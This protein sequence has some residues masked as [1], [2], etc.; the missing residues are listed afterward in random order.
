MDEQ[1]AKTK[2]N[3]KINVKIAARTGYGLRRSLMRQPEKSCWCCSAPAAANTNGL[4]LSI[5]ERRAGRFLTSM[6]SPR[7][8][9]PFLQPILSESTGSR[10]LHRPAQSQ[11]SSREAAKTLDG[12]VKDDMML[13][14]E[15]EWPAIVA[16]R[17][18]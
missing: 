5:A 9:R 3:V 6:L 15:I 17:M 18:S 4:E 16:G 10:S 2:L 12:T 7:S 8:L 14:N 11:E 13:V 1:A